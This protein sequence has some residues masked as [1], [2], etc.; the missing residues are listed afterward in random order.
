MMDVF[1]ATVNSISVM[2]WR[3]YFFFIIGG[4]LENR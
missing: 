4:K 1:K 3:Y 2:S